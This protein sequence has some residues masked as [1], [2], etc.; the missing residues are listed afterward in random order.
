LGISVFCKIFCEVVETDLDIVSRIDYDL[1]R[2]YK[3]KC[4]FEESRLLE[5]NW[6][7]QV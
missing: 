7:M 5:G 2:V 1:K 3:V 4:N 6:S